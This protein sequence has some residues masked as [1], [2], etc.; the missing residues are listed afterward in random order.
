MSEILKISKN[1]NHAV[2]RTTQTSQ[3]QRDLESKYLRG[4][5]MGTTGH[6]MQNYEIV[7]ISDKL[8]L[9]KMGNIKSQL[10][11]KFHATTMNSYPSQ[12]RS[13][14]VRRRGFCL[15]VSLIGLIQLNS[16]NLQRYSPLPLSI[17]HKQFHTSNDFV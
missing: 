9:E 3:F 2:D 10:L 12:R 14:S 4:C 11:E 6:N 8:M 7:V 15:L 16:A 5:T 17:I 1:V 13:S